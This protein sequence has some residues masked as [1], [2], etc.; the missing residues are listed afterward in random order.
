ML[1]TITWHV[2]VVDH[3]DPMALCLIERAVTED[4]ICTYSIY[5]I[6]GKLT[7]SAHGM[8]AVIET[9]SLRFSNTLH[10]LKHAE[11]APVST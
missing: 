9:L 6:N 1:T 8:P 3:P 4:R 10:S 11:E 5:D 7:T 2:Y